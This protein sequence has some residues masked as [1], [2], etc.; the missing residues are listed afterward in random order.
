MIAVRRARHEARWVS[1]KSRRDGFGHNLR[2]VILFN[3]VPHAEKKTRVRFEYAPGL[4]EA[5][6]LVRIE[7]HPELTGESVE[8]VVIKW[9]CKCIGLPPSH[10]RGTHLSR[11]I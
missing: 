8:C 3:A 1:R 6:L 2:E 11:C 4:A 10:A 9:K 5:A 7:H